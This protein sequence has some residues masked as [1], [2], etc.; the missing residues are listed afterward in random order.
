MTFRERA[1]AVVA[2]LNIQSLPERMKIASEIE[3]E[4]RSFFEEVRLDVEGSGNAPGH[5]APAMVKILLDCKAKF[6]DP[7]N[8]KQPV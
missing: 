6:Y 4:L 5:H 1:H 3:K 2:R 7:L 8:K